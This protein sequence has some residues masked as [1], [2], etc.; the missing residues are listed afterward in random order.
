M[1]IIKSS[2]PHNQSKPPPATF[3]TPD[4][5][6]PAPRPRGGSEAPRGRTGGPEGADPSRSLNRFASPR[7]G[8]P[9]QTPRVQVTHWGV[10]ETSCIIGGHRERRTL[11][12]LHPATPYDA[13]GFPHLADPLKSRVRW[14]PR[15]PMMYGFS[16][17]SESVG[18]IYLM[19]SVTPYDA[20]RFPLF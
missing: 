2:C 11:H 17:V 15:P 18:I 6:S 8:P 20:R 16:T 4:F 5:P 19:H 13:R 10:P 9:P 14:L 3:P 1:G 7:V 12:P